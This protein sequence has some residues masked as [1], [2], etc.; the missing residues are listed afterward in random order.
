MIFILERRNLACLRKCKDIFIRFIRLLRGLLGLYFGSNLCLY[1]DYLFA[2][3]LFWSVLLLLSL[4]SNIHFDFT[5]V[6]LL[7]FIF[8]LLAAGYLYS[9]CF[10][11]VFAPTGYHLWTFS[12]R[13]FDWL[14]P[15]CG[16]VSCEVQRS[17]NAGSGRSHANGL[18]PDCSVVHTSKCALYYK[19]SC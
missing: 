12:Y 9:S 16:G 4:G 1:F 2:L 13:L 6:T 19:T 5:F 7:D 15:L 10:E 8:S 18:I 3:D 17:R 11:V 14:G